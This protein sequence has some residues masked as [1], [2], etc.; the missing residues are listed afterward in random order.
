MQSY[1]SLAVILFLHVVKYVVKPYQSVAMN[2]RGSVTQDLVSHALFQPNLHV[3]VELLLKSFLVQTH[4]KSSSAREHV[5]RNSL[6][7]DIS[8]ATHAVQGIRTMFATKRVIRSYHV[9]NTSVQTPVVTLEAALHVGMSLGM[10]CHVTADLKSFCLQSL[11]GLKF[12]FVVNRVQDVETVIILPTIL[13]I[14]KM[15]VLHVLLP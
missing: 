2:A 10:N 5:L 12:L 3:D 8:V 14:L 13:V 9:D 15:S 7:V 11:V 4:L 6:V 1:A